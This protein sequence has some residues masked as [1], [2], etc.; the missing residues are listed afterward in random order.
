[1]MGLADAALAATT[2]RDKEGRAFTVRPLA[3][4]DRSALEA[5][6]AGFEPKRAAQG[7]P[8]E[9]AARVRRWLDA[10]LPQGAHLAVTATDGALIGHALLVPTTRERVWEYAIFLHQSLRGRGIGTVVNRRAIELARTLGLRGVWLCVQPHN[11]A[12]LRSYEKA[13]FRYRP[14]TVL[15]PEMEM[16]FGLEAQ[17]PGQNGS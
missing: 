14:N 13:G 11:R 16:E 8:P 1:M 10:V 2:H 9:G 12:A 5:F 6:Y 15:S 7:L 4:E 3:P 17:A